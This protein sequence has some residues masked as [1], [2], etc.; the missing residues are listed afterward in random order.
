[1]QD[2]EVQFRE[3]LETA[4]R[5]PHILAFWLDGSRGKGIITSH[6]DYD[7]TMIVADNVLQEYRAKYE[8]LG[9]PDV[10]LRVFTF[11][12]FKKYAAWGGPEAW[13]RYNFAYLKALMDKTG[14]AQ[15]LIEEKA[16][17]PPAE[18]SKFIHRSLDHYINQV[19]RSLKC[20][21]DGQFVGARL[22]AAEAIN[23]LLDA[24][25]AL[26]GRLRPYPKY[27]E[28]ELV[29]CPLSKWGVD[30]DEFLKL[31]LEILTSGSPR[32]QQNL[33][34]RVEIVFRAEGYGSVFDAWG[35]NL[36]R[37]RSRP[38]T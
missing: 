26:N 10:E 36:A 35:D 22:E 20:S 24:I 7:C 29:K 19:Y 8:N 16:T 28:W 18:V 2:A 27:L 37:L 3:I 38:G 6:S 34:S 9:N 31:L 30:K 23:P 5:D 1:M 12:E 33:L 32:D 14:E 4:E 21:R 17:I 15:K 11:D 25:F 13:D